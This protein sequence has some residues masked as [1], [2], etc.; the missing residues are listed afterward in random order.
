MIR[1]GSRSRS[2]KL[3]EYNLSVK[4]KHHGSFRW[5][6][7][8]KEVYSKKNRLQVDHLHHLHSLCR[9]NY[10][11]DSYEKNFYLKQYCCFRKIFHSVNYEECLLLN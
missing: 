6:L 2:E 8:L 10:N 4:K 7:K 3:Q 5:T 1:V 9:G 11:S